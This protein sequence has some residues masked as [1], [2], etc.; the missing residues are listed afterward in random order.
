MDIYCLWKTYWT[1]IIDCWLNFVSVS[2]FQAFLDNEFDKF[3]IFDNLRTLSLSWCFLSEHDVHKFKALGRFLQNS[4]NL[5]KLT[6]QDFWV[7]VPNIFSLSTILL[8]VRGFQW[9]ASKSHSVL[10]Y[11]KYFEDT[12]RKVRR[13]DEPRRGPCLVA[14]L[15]FF[16][17]KNTNICTEY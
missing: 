11:W 4:H 5:E 14:S 6:L 16:F 12:E 3:P 8:W 15:N 9:P 17:H 1:G 7:G 2:V 10:Y 13:I